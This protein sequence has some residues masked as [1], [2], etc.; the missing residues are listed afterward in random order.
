[1]AGSPSGLYPIIVSGQSSRN[2]SITYVN[3]VLV[4]LEATASD[5]GDAAITAGLTGNCCEPL[6]QADDAEGNANAV[7]NADTLAH[8]NTRLAAS[9]RPAATLHMIGGG[10]RLPA[11]LDADT[12][13][14]TP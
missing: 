5:M 9:T 3:G 4:V 7:A 12:D 1:V 11:G 8:F 6:A 2:Y 14:R 13:G 10:M